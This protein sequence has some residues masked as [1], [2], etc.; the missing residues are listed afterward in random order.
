MSGMLFLGTRMMEEL[1]DFY[2]SKVG[3]NIWLE[4]AD[5]IVLKHGNLLLGFCKREE[6]DTSGILTFLYENKSAVDEMFAKLGQFSTTEPKENEKYKIY[7]FFASDPEGRRVEFQS[8]LHPVEPYMAGDDLLV[9]RR[10]I[11]HFSKDGIPDEILWKVLELCRYSPTSRNTESYDFIVVKDR[12]KLEFLASLRGES[13]APIARAPMAVIVTADPS[14]SKRH[15]QDGC[16][17]AYHFILA[18]KMHGLGTCWIAAMD[19]DAVKV[20]LEIPNDHYV[21]TITPLGYPVEEPDIPK[22][23]NA[24]EMVRFVD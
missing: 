3:M 13:S 20:A 15:L 6:V 9:Q 17:A 7:H 14:K 4:Q 11:R 12:K 21:A 10:S 18:A 5:C 24:K 22:K 8:F 19:R 1:K 16:I 23:R 2:I